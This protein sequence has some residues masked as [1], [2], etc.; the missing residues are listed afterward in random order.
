MKQRIFSFVALWTTLAILLYFFGAHAGIGLIVVLAAVAQYELYRLFEKMDLRPLKRLGITA[1]VVITI[2][3]YYIDGLDSGNELFVLMFVCVG[4]SII[5][6]DLKEGRLRSFI[7]TLFGL[8]F[9]PYLLH[10][11]IKIAKLAQYNGL[12]AASGVFLTVWVVAVAKSSDVGGLLIGREIGKTQ[13]SVIS[14]NKTVEGAIGGIATSIIVAIALTLCFPNLMP[15]TLHWW[16][17][18]LFAIPIAIASIA[19]DLAESAFK[20]QAGVKDSGNLFPGI[21]GAFDLVDSLTLVSPIAYLLFRY[22]VF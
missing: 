13:L 2:T 17:A 6:I 8:I 22:T 21:G 1:G 18:G 16:M 9:I 15:D 7:P 3:S 11:L 19:A 10:Y 12:S 5:I 14:P 20:R 4:I